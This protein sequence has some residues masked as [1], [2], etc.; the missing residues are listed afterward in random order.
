M[1]AMSTATQFYEN[2]WLDIQNQ[3]I[4]EYN[5]GDMFGAQN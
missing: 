4:T 3:L 2:F 5:H 1:I